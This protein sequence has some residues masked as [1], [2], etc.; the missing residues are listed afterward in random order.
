MSRNLNA[1]LRH[2][3]A[4]VANAVGASARTHEMVKRAIARFLAMSQMVTA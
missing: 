2:L 1:A 3:L 4:A